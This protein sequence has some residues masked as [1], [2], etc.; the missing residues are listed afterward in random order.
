MISIYRRDRYG[1][2]YGGKR[3]SMGPSLRILMRD[4]VADILG[5][6]KPCEVYVENVSTSIPHI[7][8]IKYRELYL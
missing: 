6:A 8:P 1:E 7:I 4:G 3:L 5:V 2:S